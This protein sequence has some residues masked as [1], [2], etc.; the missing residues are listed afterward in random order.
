MT[1]LTPSVDAADDDR[2]SGEVEA[3]QGKEAVT[4]G[5]PD[6]TSIARLGGLSSAVGKA[7]PNASG[8]SQAA[9]GMGATVSGVSD[10]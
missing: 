5:V 7:E 9:P 4:L 2:E 1:S 6:L 10:L 3:D 8:H